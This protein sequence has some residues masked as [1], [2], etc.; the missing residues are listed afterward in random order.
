M[1]NVFPGIAVK[2]VTFSDLTQIENDVES[3]YLLEVPN[4]LDIDENGF[5]FFFIRTQKK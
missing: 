5:S 3:T 2:E 4:Y 1:A